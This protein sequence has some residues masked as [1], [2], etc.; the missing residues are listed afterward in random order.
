MF[1]FKNLSIGKNL[2]NKKIIGEKIQ[3]IESIIFKFLLK[4]Q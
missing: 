4:I 2:F 1:D 3:I